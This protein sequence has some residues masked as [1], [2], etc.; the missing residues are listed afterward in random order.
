MK[1]ANLIP[2]HCFVKDDALRRRVAKMG[3]SWPTHVIAIPRVGDWI[4]NSICR[5]LVVLEVMHT[6]GVKKEK[7]G[8]ILTLGEPPPCRECGRAFPGNFNSLEESL[9]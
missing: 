8:I 4:R 6:T 7:A 3:G 1:T 5:G 2:V 9:E